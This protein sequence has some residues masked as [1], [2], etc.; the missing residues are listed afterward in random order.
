MT[1]Q[2][3]QKLEKGIKIDKQL[4]RDFD[5][6]DDGNNPYYLFV[7][8]GAKI[9]YAPHGMLPSYKIL[10]DVDIYVGSS[11]SEKDKICVINGKSHLFFG[12]NNQYSEVLKIAPDIEIVWIDLNGK[13]ISQDLV[14]SKIYLK[15]QEKPPKGL[16]VKRG[17]KGGLYYESKAPLPIERAPIPKFKIFPSELR[18]L[19]TL[20]K[21][22][23]ELKDSKSSEDQLRVAYD[24]WTWFKEHKGGI[25][26][27]GQRI[28]NNFHRSINKKIR[29]KLKADF[30]AHVGK[31]KI[32]STAIKIKAKLKSE[33]HEEVK[34]ASEEFIASIVPEGAQVKFE[35]ERIKR[36]QEII[37]DV[38]AKYDLHELAVAFRHVTNEKNTRA[39][40]IKSEN[41]LKELDK[42]KSSKI[43]STVSTILGNLRESA[44]SDFDWEK[45]YYSKI[46]KDRVNEYYVRK[47]V[48]SIDISNTTRL[49]IKDKTITEVQELLKDAIIKFSPKVLKT[50]NLEHCAIK[51]VDKGTGYMAMSGPYIL[52]DKTFFPKK[53]SAE[54]NRETIIS[55]FLHELTHRYEDVSSEFRNAERA[56]FNKRTELCKIT[57]A[58]AWGTKYDT[59]K[60]RWRSSYMGRLYG[61]DNYE[62]TS[63]T[64]GD[65]G[66][67]E[68]TARDSYAKDPE[69]FMFTKEALFDG[70]YEK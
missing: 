16:E 48:E 65:I 58:K 21:L 6:F 41:L 17:P 11:F 18:N 4:I 13:N 28:F 32:S 46:M 35:A 39:F 20:Q 24:M 29:A 14:K 5:T 25:S 19:T 1:I 27:D 38:T 9:I 8:N 45:I 37:S 15:P 52:I 22:Y 36:N 26:S 57:S 64:I 70:R 34:T 44:I 43:V 56:L 66:A 42:I 7:F 59:Y 55:G 50:L 61:Y 23:D 10:K 33:P 68:Y 31:P 63:S 2:K 51:I 30:D 12:K 67:G 47:A 54:V 3:I 62:I 69:M 53:G 40:L 49:E 60:D